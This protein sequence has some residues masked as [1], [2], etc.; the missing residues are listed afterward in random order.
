MG[1]VN[2]GTLSI[3]HSQ[4]RDVSTPHV[5]SDLSEIWKEID[6]S[7]LTSPAASVTFSSIPS[8][9]TYFM[10]MLRGN[11]AGAA[12]TGMWMQFN[13]DS[14]N[15]YNVQRHYAVNAAVTA[16]R[17][18]NQSAV[19]F[20]ALTNTA[21]VNSVNMAYV[22]NIAARVKEVLGWYGF[23]GLEVGI[24]AGYW[25]NT[26]DEISSITIGTTDTSNMTTGTDVYLL[27]LV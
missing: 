14:G 12:A 23:H 13:S 7:T 25:N 27:G 22:S 5:A 15:N 17:A 3:R 20:G 19:E 21:N 18:T 26:A 6:R 24:K 10:I 8:G 9:Y 11:T 4:L 16:N 2:Y 1:M